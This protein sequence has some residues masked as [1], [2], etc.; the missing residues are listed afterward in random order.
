MTKANQISVR[1]TDPKDADLLKSWLMQPGV[2]RWFPMFDEREVEDAVK[3][4]VGYS[5]Y[6]ACFTAEW[7]G[8]PCGMA[9][10]YLQPYKKLSHQ[11][12]FAIIVSENFRNK[13][14]GKTLLEHIME[15]AKEK[16]KIELLHLEVY[17][18]NPAINLYRRMGFKEY[19]IEPRFIK[20]KGEYI[21]KIMMQKKL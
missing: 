20:E 3:I 15:K 5:K 6:E 4:W 21:S 10:L 2:L 9:N 16:F 11:C 12:L 7:N 8:E 19:G 14:V 13:G 1:V 17:Q 18:G